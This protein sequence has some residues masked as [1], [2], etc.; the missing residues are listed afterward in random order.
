MKKAIKEMN[1]VASNIKWQPC[2]A[3][4]LQLVIGKGLSSIKLL[5]LRTKRLIDFFKT[6]AKR[7]IRKYT[8][9]FTN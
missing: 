1:S 8:K 3:Y 2:A 6:Q 5:I 9:K 7:T 4:T